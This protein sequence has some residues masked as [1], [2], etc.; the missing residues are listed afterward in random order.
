[1]GGGG[2]FPTSLLL[3]CLGFEFS[4]S[5]ETTRGN[6]QAQNG[7]AAKLV[8]IFIIFHKGFSIMMSSD[9]YLF[10]LLHVAIS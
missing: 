5:L 1:M 2:V 8:H 4:I 7:K 9:G 6:L 3:F 10:S